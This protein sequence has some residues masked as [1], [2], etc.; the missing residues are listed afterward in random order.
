MD[1]R[2]GRSNCLFCFVF[3]QSLCL[4]SQLTMPKRTL[5]KILNELREENKVFYKVTRASY[6]LNADP[7]L[8]LS[9]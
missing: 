8:V 3:S 6:Q 1:F 5:D 7:S 9:E 2:M 4:A